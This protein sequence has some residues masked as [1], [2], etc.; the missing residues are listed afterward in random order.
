MMLN[1]LSI[2][3]A[4]RQ[5]RLGGDLPLLFADVI[6]GDRGAVRDASHA[7]DRAAAR[8]HRL[9]Q[10][11]FSG[12]CVPDDGKVADVRRTMACHDF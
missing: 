12:R 2:Q 1:F 9:A 4:C 3:V 7:V 11:G 8:Q 6:V 5:G 10:D